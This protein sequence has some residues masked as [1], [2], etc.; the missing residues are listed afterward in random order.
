ML[1][2]TNKTVITT[3]FKTYYNKDIYILWG[4]QWVEMGKITVQTSILSNVCG[5]TRLLSRSGIGNPTYCPSENSYGK[6]TTTSIEN[7]VF[8]IVLWNYQRDPEGTFQYLPIVSPYF[9]WLT[10][11]P[12]WRNQTWASYCCRCKRAASSAERWKVSCTFWCLLF[13]CR[14]IAPIHQIIVRHLYQKP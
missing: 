5:A 10:M 7:F 2:L 12:F 3:L 1:K 14:I 6:A 8:H 13:I 4:L 11:S 9:V